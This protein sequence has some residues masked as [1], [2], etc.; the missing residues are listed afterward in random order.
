MSATGATAREETAVDLEARATVSVGMAVALSAIAMTFAALLLAYGIL[1]VQAPAWPPPGEPVLPSLWGLRGAATAAAFASS[2]SMRRAVLSLMN[3]R[4]RQVVGN[5]VGA[6]VAGAAFL[7]LQIASLVALRRAGVA[8]SS[9]IVASVVYALTLFH[10]LHAL[11]A[12]AVLI[13][14]LRAA[15]RRRGQL[16]TRLRALASFWHLVTAVWLVVF[17]TVFVA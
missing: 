1:R 16:V 7:V 4:P 14:V 6:G 8:P 9:G 2:L 5:L 12:L 13:P 15:M 17:L 3:S 10:G 11:V